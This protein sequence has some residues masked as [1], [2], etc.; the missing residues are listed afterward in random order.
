MSNVII[1]RGNPLY[2]GPPAPHRPRC[3]WGHR[4]RYM[5]YRPGSN[6]WKCHR[7]GRVM[8]HTR[9]LNRAEN[10]HQWQRFL[11]DLEVAMTYEHGYADPVL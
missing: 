4:E 11:V 10:V 7:C 1:C 2:Y 8:S 5:R 9:N 6:T 3:G